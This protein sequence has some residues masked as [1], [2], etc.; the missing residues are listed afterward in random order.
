M[1]PANKLLVQ[2][3]NL[4]NHTVVPVHLKASK[5]TDITLW[6]MR[7]QPSEQDVKIIWIDLD[8]DGVRL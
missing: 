8:M 1:F 7:L 6:L 2:I 4:G 3:K 5:S